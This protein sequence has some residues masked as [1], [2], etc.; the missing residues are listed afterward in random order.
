MI[1]TLELSNPLRIRDCRS[2]ESP[3]VLILREL[4]N[5]V[6]RTHAI[7]DLI[8]RQ[9]PETQL[10][11]RMQEDLRQRSFSECTVRHFT[12]LVSEF[13]NRRTRSSGGTE[14]V[15]VAQ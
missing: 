5:W 1:S 14:E 12:H 10:R 3:C 4:K 8:V 9:D 13:A 15:S 2:V 7:P 11:R 6:P